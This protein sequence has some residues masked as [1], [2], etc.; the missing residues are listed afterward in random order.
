MNTIG[1][2]IYK[3]WDASVK[4]EKPNELMLSA[5]YE[6]TDA[7]LFLYSPNMFYNRMNAEIYRFNFSY[8]IQNLALV[9]SYYQ[10][11]ELSDKNKGNDFMFR[12]GKR[13][14]SFGMF[15][16]EYFFSDY[17]ANSIFYYSPQDFYTHSI[18]SEYDYEYQKEW[19]LKFGGKIGYAPVV[20]YVIGE[21]FGEVIY[22]PF[23]N[24]AVS[25]R[26][27]YGNSFRYGLGYQSF[28]GSLTAYWNVF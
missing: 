9:K 7:R 19:K 3:V 24:L 20:D 26:A 28:N 4:Y 5:N 10:Y 18:W 14:L 15:G 1:E 8:N 25:A 6:S 27:T 22:N 17:A 12:L 16:Y 2:P 23:Q 13:F 11:F 21:I